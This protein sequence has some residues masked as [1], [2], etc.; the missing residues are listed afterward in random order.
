MFEIAKAKHDACGVTALVLLL[1]VAGVA[2]CSSKEVDTAV[3]SKG[4][5]EESFSEPGRTRLES[6]YLI[7]MPVGGLIERIEL[8]PGDAVTKGE[9]LVRY[10]EVPFVETVA[11]AAE[12]VA[13]I[14]AAIAVK[15]DNSIEETLLLEATEW[16][17]AT[18]ELLK[19]AD[20]EVAAEKARNE[21]ASKELARMENLAAENAISESALDDVRLEADTALISLKKEMF[22]RAAVNIMATIVGLG[23]RVIN[24]YMDLE[25]LQA[26]ELG[27]QLAQARSRLALARRELEL[28]RVESPI[29]GVVLQ[30]FEQGAQALAVGAQLLLIGSLDELEVE[31]DILT[32]D[33]MKL[34]TGQDVRLQAALDSGV[35]GG[36]VRKVEPAGF[37]K[38]SSL[39]VEQQRVKA[40]I[41]IDEKPQNLGVGYRVMATFVTGAKDDALKLPRASVLQAVDRSHY[42]FKVENGRLAKTPVTV[43]MKSDLELEITGG[44][45]EGDTVVSRPDTTLEDGMKVKVK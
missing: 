3:P 38:L 12:A 11:E 8:E 35:M 34:A 4:S 1:L 26:N 2:G 41:S 6:T 10:D 23:P 31:V 14:E 20:E 39:G 13:Q 18:A 42:V 5:I 37:T 44:L 40:I 29:D 24:E 36:K 43:G 22:N 17:K 27:H 15:A 30:R 45:A 21:R 7:T 32:V 25:R 28:T 33:A 9:T 16:I 19:A